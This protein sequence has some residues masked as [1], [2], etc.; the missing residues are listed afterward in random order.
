MKYKVSF[1]HPVGAGGYITVEAANEEEAKAAI[2]ELVGKPQ[3]SITFTKIEP[4]DAAPQG[5]STKE[6]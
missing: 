2:A 6:G 3:E 1:T 4:G 5:I